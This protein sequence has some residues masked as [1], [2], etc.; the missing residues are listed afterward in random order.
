MSVEV[1]INDIRYL[2]LISMNAQNIM[3][4]TLSYVIVTTVISCYDNSVIS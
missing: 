3:E 4:N 1:H 2:Q